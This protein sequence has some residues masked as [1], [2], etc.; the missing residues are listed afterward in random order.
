MTL[1]KHI[2]LFKIGILTL[3]FPPFP[4]RKVSDQDVD[5]LSD[6]LPV[7]FEVQVILSPVVSIPIIVDILNLLR[8]KR[9][10]SETSPSKKMNLS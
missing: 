10:H 1:H 8:C 9:S 3:R 6:E 2:I 4:L 7:D 5:E